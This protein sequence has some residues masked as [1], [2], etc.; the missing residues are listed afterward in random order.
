MDDL[1]FFGNKRATD[2]TI[3]NLKQQF[4]MKFV[5]DLREYIGCSINFEN[6]KGG[7]VAYITQPDILKK[8]EKK[9]G[10]EFSKLAKFYGTPVC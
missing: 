2:G 8:T 7:K 3:H 9:F 5:G 1:A 10:N 6:G 4:E